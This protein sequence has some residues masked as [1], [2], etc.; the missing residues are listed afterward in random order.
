ME[1]D[2]TKAIAYTTKI[3]DAWLPWKIQYDHVPGLAIGIVYRGKLVYQNGFGYADVSA[4]TPMTSRTGFRIAS[5]SKTFTAVSIM[6][7]VEQGKINL[8]DHIC[9]HVP[10]FKVHTKNL[11]TGN[12]TIRQMLSHAAG[13]WRDGD[14]PHWELDSFPGVAG[15]KKSMSSRAIVFENLTGFKYSNFGFAVLGQVI[16][17][18]S[19]MTYDAYVQTHIIQK[20]GMVHT[21]PD[22]NGK[23]TK[24]LANGYSR[25]IPQEERTVFTH[26]KTNAYASA[27]GFISNVVDLA[28]YLSALSLQRKQTDLLLH[29]ESKKEMMMEYWHTG[30]REEAYGLGFDVYKIEQRKIVGHSGGFPGFVTECALDVSNDIGV[31]V[32]TNTNDS[33]CSAILTSVFQM[34]YKFVDEKNTYCVGKKISQQRRFEGLFR[35]RFRD[36]LVVGIGGQLISFEPQ[37]NYPSHTWTI[38]KQKTHNQFQMQMKQNFD[39]KNETAHF[40]FDQKNKPATKLYYG[41]TPLER[42]A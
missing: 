32:L 39:Y 17:K 29:R 18:V 11:T 40:V 36:I 13:V 35:S 10:W 12:I 15:L 4:N 31:I 2:Y 1:N 16:K 30:V 8:D 33:S 38:F 37:I 25:V 41:P 14:T 34:M 24:W 27:T 5:I 23:N 9:K 6:Q 28:R 20:L 7:L 26:C 3:I 19:G 21:A 42:V 22:F